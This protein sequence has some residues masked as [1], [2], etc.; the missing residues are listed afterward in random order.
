VAPLRVLLVLGALLACVPACRS[1][2]N[3]SASTSVA[4]GHAICPVCEAD[5]DLACQDVKIRSDTPSTTRDGITY[6]FC[7]AECRRK[8]EKDPQAYLGR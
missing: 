5:G 2:A 1:A 3:A 6:Y 7:S 4:P 8:F